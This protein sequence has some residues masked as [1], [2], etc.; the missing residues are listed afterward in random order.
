MITMTRREIL[1]KKRRQRRRRRFFKL[2]A[3]L[4]LLICAFFAIKSF[5]QGIIP[6][7]SDGTVY[8][9]QKDSKWGGLPYGKTSTIAESGCGPTCVAMVAST[10]TSNHIT[11]EDACSWAEENGQYC[12][13]SGSFHSV[14]AAGGEHYGF[15]VTPIKTN[16]KE[17][18]T[19]SLQ[20]GK[21]I[22][23]LMGKGH[24][25]SSGH[26]ILLKGIT[27]SG[28]ILVSDSNSRLRSLKTWDL[29]IILNEAKSNAASGGPFWLC[30]PQ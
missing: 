13:G 2:T 21:L 25:T 7:F 5:G 23:A 28:K 24:F 30:T 19:K 8:Y 26:F 6:A 12:E 17:T 20:D 1:Q 9:S 29:D 10:F 4:T 15:T 3:T 11:P 27:D 14:I 22:V 16:K 18:I